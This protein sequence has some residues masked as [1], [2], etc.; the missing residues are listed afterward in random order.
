MIRIICL[1]KVKE[2]YLTDGIN[3]YKKRLSKYTKVEIVELVD[4][5]NLK[6]ESEAILS[7]INKK[8]YIITLDIDGE[9]IDSV[10]FS[11]KLENCFIYKPNVTFIIGSS[12]GLDP[13]IKEKS[14]YRFSFS[15]L[16]FPHQ[17]FRMMLLE[18]IYRCYKI[19][20]NE[21]YHK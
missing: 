14:D 12:F 1:G 7:K 19:S 6:K 11:K 13:K 5:N 2:K 9:M 20:N 15:K 21:T 16:T 4:T 8:D 10:T 17:L 3:E 18:Q